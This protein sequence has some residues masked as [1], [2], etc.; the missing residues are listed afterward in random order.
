MANLERSRENQNNKEGETKPL[1]VLNSQ[2]KLKKELESQQEKQATQHKSSDTGKPEDT[3]TRKLEN[4][5]GT[6]NFGD[7]WVEAQKSG[8][9]D[10]FRTSSDK[11]R[12][13]LGE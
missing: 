1:H 5:S 12:S 13:V 7:D 9:L 8:F 10:R 2:E 11:A 4:T 3:S 6:S